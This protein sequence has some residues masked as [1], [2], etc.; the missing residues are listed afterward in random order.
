MFGLTADGFVKKDLQTIKSEIEI[1]LKSTFGQDIDISESSVFGQIVG[2]NAKRESNIWDLA[3]EVYSSQSPGN[4]EGVSLDRVMA[5]LNVQ[6][7]DATATTV[8]ALLSGTAGTI[9]TSGSLAEQQETALQYSLNSNV[10]LNKSNAIR[11]LFEITTVLD[12]TLYTIIV[13]GNTIQYT[14]GVG[15]TAED[16]INGL[17]AQFSLS[18]YTFTDNLDGTAYIL[19]NDYVTEWAFTEDANMTVN[20]VSRNG[21]FTCTTAGENSLPAQTLNII[22]TPISGWDSINNISAGA[23]GTD[24]ETDV[25][26]RQ[27]G[28]SAQRSL[29]RG[30]EEAIKGRLQII[31]NVS[32]VLVISNRENTTDVD[33]RPAKSYEAVVLGGTDQDIADEL[34]LSQPA[35]IESYGNTTVVV[36]DSELNS[37]T[38]KFSRPENIY[39]WI[40]ID[41]T[42]YDEEVFPTN[43]TD[44]VK[45]NIVVFGESEYDIGIDVL[46][47][48]LYQ[49]VFETSGIASATIKLGTSA[50]PSTPPASYTEVDIAI[51]SREIASIDKTRM[52][53]GIV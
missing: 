5:L 11:V 8:Q 40:E 37:Q 27:R 12:A 42:L 4:A 48:R 47:Q 39:V 17:E 13:D 31:P 7:L 52:I 32:S 21:Q 30:T 36:T 26:L 22:V 28:R 46:R 41:L 19:R 50:N 44:Q 34:W 43:G 29:G 14:S 3:E 16:I 20:E 6:R 2:L 25:E 45:D 53:V 10:T 15:A 33:G 23:T 18:D 51:S 35:G 24:E 38:I 9:I 49:P 1:E